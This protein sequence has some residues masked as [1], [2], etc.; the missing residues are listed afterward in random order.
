MRDGV[1]LDST[2]RGL[3]KTV[4]SKSSKNQSNP[5]KKQQTERVG[6][7]ST[8]DNEIEGNVKNTLNEGI[9]G[10]YNKAKSKGSPAQKG[11]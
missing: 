3:N 2:V 7:N 10:A 8:I 6:Q 1:E 5:L 9:K 11:R 4:R